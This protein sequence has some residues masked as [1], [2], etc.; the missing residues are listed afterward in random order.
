MINNEEIQPY[1]YFLMLISVRSASQ[2][3]ILCYA[4]TWAEIVIFSSRIIFLCYRFKNQH[5]V[6][7]GHHK[8]GMIHAAT[9]NESG[10]L[11]NITQ[12]EKQVGKTWTN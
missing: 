5:I 7:A 1:L 11:T 8:G 12:M 3:E 2:R 6:M 9:V 10:L 4:K